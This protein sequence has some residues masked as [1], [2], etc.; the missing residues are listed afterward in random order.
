MLKQGL[1][2]NIQFEA[3]RI[4]YAFVPHVG[5]Q[6]VIRQSASHALLVGDRERSR[7][8]M[9]DYLATDAP[10]YRVNSGWWN[11]AA[12]IAAAAVLL[13]AIRAF[14]GGV[15]PYSGRQQ[16]VHPAE[17]TATHS[18]LSQPDSAP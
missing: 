13:I 12:I 15:S 17:P 1:G 7:E 3:E 16:Q 5:A 8:E 4:S 10:E 2:R 14:S 6:R 18:I 11:L 9:T